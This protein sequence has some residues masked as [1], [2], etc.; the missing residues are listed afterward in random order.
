MLAVPFL[1]GCLDRT[2]ET[3]HSVGIRRGTA[4]SNFHLQRDNLQIVGLT[5]PARV[6]D[7]PG[8]LDG[9]GGHLPG[10]PGGGR[11][12]LRGEI[13]VNDGEEKVPPETTVG[14]SPPRK[15]TP[16]VIQASKAHRSRQACGQTLKP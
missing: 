12:L 6:F 2:P 7:I 9:H 4:T 1:I 8:G 13:Q 16:S 10:H 11:Y 14:G 5:V 3:Y 15:A